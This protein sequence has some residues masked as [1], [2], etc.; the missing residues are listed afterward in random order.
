MN[1]AFVPVLR[2]N[3]DKLNTKFAYARH[4]YP[5]LDGDVLL[6][7][8]QMMIAPIIDTVSRISL[9]RVEPV[10]LT[11]YDLSLELLGKGM[12]GT[13]T[14]YPAMVKG[15]NRIFTQSAN[16]LVQEPLLFA[17]SVLNALYNLSISQG[18][19]PN[20]WIDEMLRIGAECNDVQTYLEVGKIVAWRSGMAHYRDGALD[21]CLQLDPKLSRLSL[22]IKDD[23]NTPTNVI[24]DRLR[25]DPWLAPWAAN[26]GPKSERRLKIASVVGGFR[27]FGGV[28][29]SP[30]EVV[31]SNGDFF[32]F[33]NESC[34]LMTADLF[35]ATLH[36][37]GANLP[38]LTKTN[39]DSFTIDKK[40]RVSK[41]PY[42]SDFPELEASSSF[43]A[44][45]TTLA[46]TLPVSF[47]IYLVALKEVQ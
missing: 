6:A 39:N 34:W 32:V 24:I 37:V 25:H 26:L 29:V 17:G 22:S 13:E 1:E 19:R 18:T 30:P 42:Q 47:G 9:Q 41:S 33:D 40:G 10:L 16:L 4:T 35:G 23:A 7:H 28:F 38:D 14:R 2:E 46:V 15:W 12:I 8:M 43:A 36:K 20:Y 27:G 3:R 5:K 31:L 21:A 11:L 44:D 45:E